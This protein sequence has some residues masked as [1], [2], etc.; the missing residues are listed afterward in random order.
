MSLTKDDL[1]AIQAVVHRTVQPMIDDLAQDTAAGFAEVHEKFAEVDENFHS[2]Q[3]DVSE[4]KDTTTRIELKQRAEVEH[5]DAHG[6][7]IKL[8]KSRLKLA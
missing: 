5:V 1:D 8:I 3:S 6:E 7:D 4:I 2:L